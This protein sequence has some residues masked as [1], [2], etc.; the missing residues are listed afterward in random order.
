MVHQRRWTIAESLFQIDK[1]ARSSSASYSKDVSGEGV[2]QALLKLLE[3]TVVSV[4]DKE[5]AAG[6]RSRKGPAK[7]THLVD[8]TNIL[9]I[10]AGAFVGLDKIVAARM[11]K[12]NSIGFTAQ[13]NKADSP[14]ANLTPRL[15]LEAE[16]KK[17]KELLA[18]VEPADLF[19]YGFIQE[20]VSFFPFVPSFCVAHP[21]TLQIHRSITCYRD[22]Q[23]VVGKR[24]SA[25]IDR[26][27]K[28]SR[29]A[30]RT[31]LQEF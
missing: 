24:S 29:Q 5:G 21:S 30:V 26:T 13:L 17:Q 7:E 15:K 20:S 27:E 2:Q 12:G 19:R 31:A 10:L 3:G 25:S 14:Q 8:T 1:L 6:G 4:P 9:F 23:S 18:Q 28:R 16:Q 22:A 11:S